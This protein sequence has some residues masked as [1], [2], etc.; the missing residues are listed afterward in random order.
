MLKSIEHTPI[1]HFT[2]LI[3]F[4]NHFAIKDDFTTRGTKP[5]NFFPIA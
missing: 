3:E 2:H 1:G 4:P 5:E